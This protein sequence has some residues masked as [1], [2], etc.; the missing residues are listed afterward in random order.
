MN[1]LKTGDIKMRRRKIRLKRNV[2][3]F[4]TVLFFSFV[5]VLVTFGISGCSPDDEMV[6]KQ[7]VTL[8][9]EEKYDEAY[10]LLSPRIRSEIGNVQNFEKLHRNVEES[11]NAFGITEKFIKNSIRIDGN[12]VTFR[13][14]TT[15]NGSFHTTEILE[16]RV[17][18]AVV[19]GKVDYIQSMGAPEAIEITDKSQI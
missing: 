6:K 19:D 15:Y 3:F 2:A 1:N 7:Y 13:T 4:A 12:I 5:L 9:A 11:Y 18:I 10:R 17:Y 14:K 8:V 16:G